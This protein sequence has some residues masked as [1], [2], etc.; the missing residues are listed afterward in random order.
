MTLVIRKSR[1]SEVNRPATYC[2][3]HV[4]FSHKVTAP[5]GH[6]KT[7]SVAYWLYLEIE[8]Q[9]ACYSYDFHSVCLLLVVCETNCLTPFSRENGGKDSYLVKAN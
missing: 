8:P 9:L 1:H 3:C 4:V 2:P 5:E 7:Q 6:D